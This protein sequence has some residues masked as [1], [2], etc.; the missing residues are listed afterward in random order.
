MLQAGYVKSKQY[1][2]LSSR[3]SVRTVI[4]ADH[5]QDEARQPYEGAAGRVMGRGCGSEKAA[6]F[7]R[8]AYVDV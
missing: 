3:A 7:I 4:G 6:N 1:P 2:L 5:G 8:L